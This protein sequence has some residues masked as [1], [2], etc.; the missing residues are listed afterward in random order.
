ML[1][2]AIVLA[3]PTAAAVGTALAA[4]GAGA[5]VAL[6]RHHF[7]KVVA[8]VQSDLGFVPVDPARVRAAAEATDPRSVQTV[9][10]SVWGLDMTPQQEALITE[11]LGDGDD[12]RLRVV[13][14]HI[15]LTQAPAA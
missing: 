5:G 2:V 12:A 3:A 9:Q 4:F 15:L 6:D 13:I 11:L 14:A 10:P 7:R 8:E 1:L